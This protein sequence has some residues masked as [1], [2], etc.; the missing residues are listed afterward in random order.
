MSNIFIYEQ[1]VSDN[2]KLEKK[3]RQRINEYADETPHHPYKNLGN[4]IEIT[5]IFYKPS[6]PVRVLSQYESRS[7]DERHKPYQNQAIDER[8]LFSLNNFNSWD[9]ILP[10]V[11]DFNGE[12][13]DYRV[14]GSE[15]VE[16][17]FKCHAS[18]R[19]TCPNCNGKCYVTCPNC[20][21]SGT[22]SCGKCRG[23]GTIPTQETRSNEIYIPPRYHSDG[24][25]IGGTGMH[26]TETSYVT[27]NK[28]CSN[29]NGSGRF[30]C[31]R[32]SG[33]GKVVCPQCKAAGTIT[34]P[35]CKGWKQLLHYYNISRA[36]E[37]SDR[38][39]C[40]LHGDVYDRFP[41]YLDNYQDYESELIHNKLDNK[42]HPGQLDEEVHLNSFIDKLLTQ[43]HEEDNDSHV[44]LFQRLEI[45]RIETWELQYRFK[46]K[47]YV[48]LFVGSEYQIIPGLSPIYEVAF[49]YLEKSVKA[50]KF[51]NFSKAQRL[52]EKAAHIDVYEMQE[53][54][55]NYLYHL[56]KKV[57]S[58]YDLGSWTAGLLAL[59][60]GSFIVYTY[61]SEVNWVL[62]YAGFINNPDNFLYGYHAWSQI[63]M[64][65]VTVYYIASTSAVKLYSIGYRL[66]TAIGRFVAGFLLTGFS[67][68]L[69]MALL[70]LLN[71]V[72]I[73][74]IFTFL[75]WLTLIVLKL[76]LFL[77]T[78]FIGIV[79]FIAKIIWV[80]ISWLWNLIF[81]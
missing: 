68:L 7:K 75:V 43:A 38:E 29:C 9:I 74:V 78:L 65:M 41:E 71:W 33:K 25:Q 30:T 13:K 22:I 10:E 77:I 28:T 67:V 62:G 44:M 27:V 54:V 1:N 53:T 64:F 21:G 58:A 31:S 20:N 15:H 23:Q 61:F 8:V 57:N 5:G 79:I 3:F 37:Y 17:C 56:R 42:L 52:L 47:N 32:C 60:L 73:T 35:T 80:I 48:M 40:I 39:T 16:N 4:L 2:K 59:F 24:S 45:R 26:K 19:I 55:N 36:L 51:Y 11:K 46:N 63:I 76:V 66:P 6:Y 12:T 50:S 69:S 49:N 72:G 70:F 18:G 14:S 81:N 34:C